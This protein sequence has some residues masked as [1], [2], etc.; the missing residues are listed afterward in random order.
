MHLLQDSSGSLGIDIKTKLKVDL[1]QLEKDD[2]YSHK[3]DDLH[4]MLSV[5]ETLQNILEKR[6]Y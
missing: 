2:F 5:K 1:I 4:L 3:V 6:N